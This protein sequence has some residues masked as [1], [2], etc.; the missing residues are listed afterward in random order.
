M[1]GFVGVTLASCPTNQLNFKTR[2]HTIHSSDFNND[3]II[4]Q[5]IYRLRTMP[6]SRTEKLTKSNTSQ[7]SNKINSISSYFTK[8]T[9]LRGLRV[10][11]VLLLLICELFLP[12]EKLFGELCRMTGP[13]M[14][15]SSILEKHLRISFRLILLSDWANA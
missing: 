2:H 3:V 9:H 8:M 11:T 6:S 13:V 5:F 1:H 15:R 14:I 10:H 12:R 4:Q 7:S